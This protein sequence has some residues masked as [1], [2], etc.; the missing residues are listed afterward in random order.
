MTAKGQ[1]NSLCGES[2][3]PVGTFSNGTELPANHNTSFAYRDGLLDKSWYLHGAKPMA[4][5]KII[6]KRV[7]LPVNRALSTDLIK[8]LRHLVHRNAYLISQ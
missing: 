8:N 6:I 5:M 2:V 4:L 3:A 1:Y 7:S